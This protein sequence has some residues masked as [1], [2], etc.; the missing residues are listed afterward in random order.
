MKPFPTRDLPAELTPAFLRIVEESNPTIPEWLL[1]S[2]DPSVVEPVPPPLTMAERVQGLATIWGEAKFNFAFWDHLPGEDWW[3]ERFREYL[4]QVMA[5]ESDLA[6]W[7]LLQRFLCLL[8]DGHTNVR[9]PRHL[10]L[11]EALPP[12]TVSSVEGRPVVVAGNVLPPGTEIL[13]VDGR[14]A[15]EL[16][17]EMAPVTPSSTPQWTELRTAELLLQGPAGSAVRLSV[18]MPDGTVRKVELERS[19]KLPAP[20]DL[21][22]RDL[23]GGIRHVMLNSMG[24]LQTIERFHE[25]FPHFEGVRGLVI[26]V[27]RNGGGHTDVGY[28]VM[29]RLLTEPGQGSA[30]R[31]RTYI[32]TFRAWCLEQHWI[33]YPGDQLQPDAQRPRFS[34]PVAV[35]SS[36][37]SFSAAEDFLV[38]FKA[39]GR[40]PIIG[41]A[42]G[43]STGQPLSLQL[44]GGGSFRVCTLRQSFPDGTD[45]IGSGVQ[46]DIPCAPT[47]A[48]L[49]AGRDE[50]LERA[51]RFIQTGE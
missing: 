11:A 24:S 50:V 34:G 43:G 28:A 10:Q 23:G 6:Y 35:L 17:A 25:A 27:R 22:V 33:H 32:P 48:G 51:L 12:L 36:P 41:E 18:R 13:A 26:D 40:G 2:L 14:P 9:L 20:P 30:F 4:P 8:R 5:A 7:R 42:S 46:P 49:G 38:A 1:R 29:T 47:I 44:P 21:E 45:F 31:L 3:D 19:G 39:S 15:A 37:A 16:R